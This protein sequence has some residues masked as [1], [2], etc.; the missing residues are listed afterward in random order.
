VEAITR[1]REVSPSLP[2]LLHDSFRGIEWGNVLKD[3]PFSDVYL[4]THSYQCF[5]PWDLASD[6]PKS[7]RNKLYSHELESCADKIPFHYETCNALP[8]II[9]EFSLAVDD[10]MPFLNA[11]FEDVGQCDHLDLRIGSSYW[12]EHTRSFAMRQIATFE[13][14]LGWSFWTWKLSDW[15]EEKNAPSSWYWSFRLASEMGFIDLMNSTLLDDICLHAPPDD[16]MTS[17]NG[18]NGTDDG[19]MDDISMRGKTYPYSSVPPGTAGDEPLGSTQ[20]VT[21]VGFSTMD[22][23]LVALVSFL[24]G[25][26]FPTLL[27]INEKRSQ[28][29]KVLAVCSPFEIESHQNRRLSYQSISGDD[30][31]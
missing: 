8:I 23:S 31:F 5:N 16:Y 21:V 14:E 27:Y 18:R 9:G 29:M 17:G 19:G 3:W 25:A 11:R 26:F 1:V 30:V 13:R 20:A 24:L 6:S 10:C 4:D 22:V 12:Q 15:A 2:I 7:D 28:K